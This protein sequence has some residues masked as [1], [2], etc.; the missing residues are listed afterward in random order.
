MEL[1]DYQNAFLRKI[2]RKIKE[3]YSRILCVAPTGAG[4]TIVI[5]QIVQHALQRGRE[6]AIL[7]HLDV[8]IPQT[9]EKLNLWVPRH[10]IGVVKAGYP[11]TP[12]A[13]VQLYSIQTLARRKRSRERIKSSTVIIFDEAHTTAWS[14]IGKELIEFPS[15]R[16]I[17]GF[18]ATPWRLSRKEGMGD[19]FEV[20][21]VAALPSELQE[22]GRLSKMKYF[23]VREAD[24]SKI[25]VSRG[26]FSVP[27]LSR[28][29]Q[30]PEL[31]GDCLD[32]MRKILSPQDSAIAF[33][34]DV[35]HAKRFAALAESYGFSSAIVTGETPRNERL[36]LYQA[37]AEKNL[38]ILAS[39]NVVSIGFDLPN[40]DAGLLLRPTKSRTLHF[41]QVGR[42]MR[43]AAS[44]EFG[45][46]IDQAGNCKR[47]G[48]PELL[49]EED[50]NLD[51]G[52]E[53]KEKGAPPVKSCPR[54]SA[55]VPA[56]MLQCPNCGFE[57]PTPE[58]DVSKHR[59]EFVA[60]LPDRG[61]ESAQP[62]RKKE[63][64]RLLVKA[65]SRRYS[66]GWA[67]FKYK[68]K[69]NE[70]PPKSW[71]KHS[72]FVEPSRANLKE[73]LNYLNE[74]ALRSGKDSFWILFHARCEFG[75]DRTPQ[76]QKAMT[77]TLIPESVGDF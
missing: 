51:R 61:D 5:S 72:I 37:L 48:F 38:N 49:D 27:D 4:K 22:R 11:E 34:V 71:R 77:E 9:I 21:V 41:Q 50:L 73:Y 74:V 70:K 33:C 35:E 15:E 28:A 30:S 3:D 13:P 55:L 2:Y 64:R 52:K 45:T 25:R 66:P 14:R 43:F 24:V 20:S 32:N 19:L 58:I 57:F 29:C 76:I 26:D 62:Q 65:Y 16:I 60:L 67:L 54:C 40:L 46:I 17:L 10:A 18:T 53:S 59:G 6:V 75:F 56:S 63:Y 69:F 68:D 36:S 42:V 12:S 39:V 8:L 47:H 44:K 1:F 23:G 7:V 31:M